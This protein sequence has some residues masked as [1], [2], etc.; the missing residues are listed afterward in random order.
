MAN[1]K[2]QTATIVGRIG[3][4][5]AN[6]R[7]VFVRGEEVWIADFYLSMKCTA[8]DDPA[9]FE[10]LEPGQGVMITGPIGINKWIK[11]DT[12]EEIINF[13][14]EGKSCQLVSDELEPQTPAEAI[15]ARRGGYSGSVSF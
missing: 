9:L 10:A 8:Y 11:N 2:G 4:K 14:V 12:G 7:R 3:P 15:D 5:G 6:V 1:V 13:T